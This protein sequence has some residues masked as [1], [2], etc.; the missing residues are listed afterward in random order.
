M[1]E[2]ELKKLSDRIGKHPV[3][4]AYLFGSEAKGESGPLSDI[5]VAVFIDKRV[6]KS[7]RFDTRLRLSN[8][9]SAIMGK[10]VDLVVLN[11]MPVQLSFEVIKY[12]ELLYCSDKAAKI[13]IETEILSK[14]LDR[15]YYDKRHAE[16]AL[17]KIAS[18][19]L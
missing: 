16:L 7:G 17:E 13:D 1:N 14:Y 19:G 18:R 4:V 9:L 8:E 2:T 15:R 5:D 10:R 6:D 11:D 12:G 3:K